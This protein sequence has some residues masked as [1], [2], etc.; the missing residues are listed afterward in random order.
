MKSCDLFVSETESMFPVDGTSALWPE[1]R[2]ESRRKKKRP[3]AASP[4][5]TGP[6]NSHAAPAEAHPDSAGP[7]SAA[8][9]SPF[10]GSI[11]T[12]AR[13]PGETTTALPVGKGIV[14]ELAEEIYR[15]EKTQTELEALYQPPFR[16]VFTQAQKE[17]MDR[18]AHKRALQLLKQ[19]AQTP[20][21][22]VFLPDGTHRDPEAPLQTAT[23]FWMQL[24]LMIPGVNLLT[25]L[26]LSFRSATNRNQKAV[27]RAFLIWSVIF[28]ALLLGYLLFFF[29]SDPIN[30]MKISSAGTILL[31]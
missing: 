17:K 5:E 26:I 7:S 19:S 12:D 1:S 3:S 22:L 6:D 4:D 28:S 9:T 11:R 25:A 18:E 24:V 14:C 2:E 23:V 16:K 27:Y 21:E 8:S 15:K 20:P 29:F 10:G 13:L 30:T 31:S